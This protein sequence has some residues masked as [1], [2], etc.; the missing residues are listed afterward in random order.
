[1][2]AS[3]SRWHAPTNSEMKTLFIDEN[4]SKTMTVV[5]WPVK[6]KVRIHGE[7]GI[8]STGAGLKSKNIETK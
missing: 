6:P 1:M 4:C 2:H 8:V 3:E 7:D 5:H